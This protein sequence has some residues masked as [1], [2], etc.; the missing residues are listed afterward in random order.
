MHENPLGNASPIIHIQ[1]GWLS[2][3]WGTGVRG[4]G[5]DVGEALGQTGR[6]F[7]QFQSIPKAVYSWHRGLQPSHHDPKQ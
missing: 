1:G 2:N 5:G 6:P 3:A 7:A 4:D